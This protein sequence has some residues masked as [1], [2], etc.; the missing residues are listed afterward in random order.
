MRGLPVAI[1][2]PYLGSHLLHFPGNGV[3]RDCDVLLQG[4][5]VVLHLSDGPSHGVLAGC[6]VVTYAGDVSL[7]LGYHFG[8]MVWLYGCGCCSF[9]FGHS[10]F[11]RLQLLG[12]VWVSQLV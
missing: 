3:L 9:N 8:E 11:K 6:D 7:H 4:S 12:E 1:P 10:F 5:T 2:F